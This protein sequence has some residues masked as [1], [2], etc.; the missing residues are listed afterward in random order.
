MTTPADA[1]PVGG[2][3][4]QHANGAN[5]I[6]EPGRQGELADPLAPLACSG[7]FCSGGFCSADSGVA[8]ML[9]RG[10]SGGVRMLWCRSAAV[11]RCRGGG[12]MFL[13]VYK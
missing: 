2:R 8:E 3:T 12:E 10:L 11:T 1:R 4:R 6:A 5:G 9:V 7:G 13:S